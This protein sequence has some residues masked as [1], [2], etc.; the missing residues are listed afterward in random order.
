MSTVSPLENK[1]YARRFDDGLIDL[2]VAIGLVVIGASWML[3]APVYGAIA[4]AVLVPFWKLMRERMIEPRLQAVTFSP[5]RAA[6]TRGSLFAW[7]IFGAA[8]L[9]TEIA[10]FLYA[11]REAGSILDRLSEVVVALPAALIALGLLAGLL[12]GARRFVGYAIGAAA[13]A[14]AGALIGSEQPGVM[15]FAVGLMVLAFAV[16][17]LGRFFQTHPLPDADNAV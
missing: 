5:Q 8:V 2:F 12:I 13:I 7:F 15:I 10:I 9:L 3:D 11:S 4:P 14:V 1:L 17:R 16:V 6:K